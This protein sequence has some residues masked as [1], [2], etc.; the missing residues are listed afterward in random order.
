MIRPKS[1]QWALL[2]WSK[3]WLD[4]RL[5]PSL[6]RHGNWAWRLDPS[7]HKRSPQ[8]SSSSKMFSHQWPL[9]PRTEMPRV[10]YI[11]AW[12]TGK[13]LCSVLL[14]F[15]PS[16]L[17]TTEKRA[18]QTKIRRNS[19]SSWWGSLW[20][21]ESLWMD[22]TSTLQQIRK[23][24]P[25]W[26]LPPYPNCSPIQTLGSQKITVARISGLTCGMLVTVQTTT[27]TVTTAGRGAPNVSRATVI[28]TSQS[29]WWCVSKSIKQIHKKLITRE[30]NRCLGV[31][32]R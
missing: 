28:W 15:I 25:A 26:V 30:R 29:G 21:W 10:T 16:D 6:L 2:D 22:F 31:E 8:A 4:K 23:E 32:R 13:R 5:V 19:T 14:T 11:Q 3:R 17:F 9:Q 18:H 27:S 12:G 7:F 1:W 24:I 20:I